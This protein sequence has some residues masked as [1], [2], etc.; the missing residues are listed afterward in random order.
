MHFIREEEVI[1]ILTMII[2]I[3]FDL[4]L[5]TYIDRTEKN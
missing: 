4:F 1:I 3:K 2:Y 5:Q